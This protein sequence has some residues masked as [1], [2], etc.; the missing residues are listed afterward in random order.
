MYV[1]RNSVKTQKNTRVDKILHKFLHTLSPSY[2]TS[3]IF[4]P[5][6]IY[7]LFTL[8]THPINAPAVHTTHNNS[9]SRPI[10]RTLSAPIYFSYSPGAFGHRAIL[11]WGDRDMAG[12]FLYQ[13]NQ[14]R[15]SLIGLIIDVNDLPDNVSVDSLLYA[16]DVKCIAP[17]PLSPWHSPKIGS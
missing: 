15:F 5:L 11:T 4:S 17:P 9:Y 7:S 8:S 2:Q 12:S 13:N 16:D 1:V 14:I 6:V 10:V 3:V